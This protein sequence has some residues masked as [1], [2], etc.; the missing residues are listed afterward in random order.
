MILFEISEVTFTKDLQKNL[1]TAIQ[2]L[3]MQVKFVH[4]LL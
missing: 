1:K 3:P 2:K 4:K